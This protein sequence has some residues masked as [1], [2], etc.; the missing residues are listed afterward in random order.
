MQRIL[1]PVMTCLLFA[2]P[3]R[4]QDFLNHVTGKIGAGVSFPAD[5][6]ADHVNTGFNFTASGGPRFN[7]RFSLTLDFTLHYFNVKNSQ[8]GTETIGLPLGSMV[9]MW[10]LTL[11]PGYELIKQERFTSYVTAG[12]GLYNRRLLPAQPGMVPVEACD[13]FWDVCVT[14]SPFSGQTVTGN[15]GV[16]KGGY[17]GGGGVTFGRRT[18][19]FIEARYHR[20]FTTKAATQVIPLT[21]GISW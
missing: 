17:N 15:L 9:R 4:A 2:A 12:Y 8:Q 7:R 13:E 21:F 1:L 6:L 19:F 14:S 20:M 18:K 3:L 11:N 16:Y 10:S 5:I